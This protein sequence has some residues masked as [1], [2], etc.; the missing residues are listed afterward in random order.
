MTTVTASAVPGRWLQLWL[1]VVVM[2]A[3]ASPQYV[4]TLFVE[5]F[6]ASLNV[7]LAALQWT[8]ALF[9]IFQCGFGPIHGY[10]AGRVAPRTFVALGGV[11]VGLSWVSSSFVSDVTLLYFTYG[12]LSG[13]GTGFVYVAVIEL[14]V[15]YWP[16]RR[17]F[18]VGMVTG[19]YGF[20]AIATT[21]PIAWSMEAIGFRNT[22]IVFGLGFAVVII[23]A[24]LGMRRMP[25]PARVVGVPAKPGLSPAE[26][27][28]TP[29][30]WVMFTLMTMVAIGG[31][32]VI[33]QLGPFATSMGITKATMVMG[34][35][36]LPLALTIDRIA[37]GVT[38]PFF[39]WISDRIGREPTMFIAF[40]LEA[41]GVFMLL[42]LGH[43]PLAFVL[44]SGLVFFGWGQIYALFPSLQA[45]LFGPRYAVQNF[46][47][48]LVSTAVA[49]VLGAPVA[50]KLMEATG[51][52]NT[53]FYAVVVLDS[54]A[55][56]LSLVLLAPM[57]KS[58]REK[59]LA[60][61]E[62]A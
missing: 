24:A 51:S 27:L 14:M 2:M 45:D 38:R 17:G 62:R 11:L 5:P 44:L 3:I 43:H 58:F 55:A 21:F 6:R 4:W 16:E 22:L 48:L 8:F 25:E 15:K 13:V 50:A 53:A 20:G 33:S 19:S 28:K 41:V 46:G 18:A 36:A 29:V 34:L 35:A 56:V 10:L 39:G 31:L 42:K 12:V 49:S 61:S 47:F 54:I 23:L 26:M 30:F 40:G 59:R 60:A 57:V 32:M 7:P 52:W 9:S 1:G 37:N